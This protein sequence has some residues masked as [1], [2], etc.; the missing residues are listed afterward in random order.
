MFLKRIYV[1]LAILVVVVFV[2][3]MINTV[4]LIQNSPRAEILGSVALPEQLMTPLPT[5]EIVY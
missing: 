5:E 4:I 2:V 1:A 3:L